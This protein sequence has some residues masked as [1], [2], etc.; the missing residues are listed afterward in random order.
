MGA[1][2]P[3]PLDRSLTNSEFSE[4]DDTDLSVDEIDNPEFNK[5]RE[6]VKRMK[7]LTEKGLRHLYKGNRGY[8]EN[9]MGLPFSLFTVLPT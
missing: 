7:E 6:E 3:T 5:K 2:T 4:V 8:F 9:L 1:H